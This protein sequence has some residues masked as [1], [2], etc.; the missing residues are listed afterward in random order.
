MAA[1][2]SL[3]AEMLDELRELLAENF[4]ELINRYIADSQTRFNTLHT[5]IAQADFKVIYYEAHG[6]KGSSRN[7]GANILAEIMARLEALG[8]S[9]NPQGLAEVFADAQAEFAKVVV[10]LEAFRTAE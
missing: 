5:A 3:N 10:G 4:N 2:A 1:D 8:Q 9:Q 6:I 7:M